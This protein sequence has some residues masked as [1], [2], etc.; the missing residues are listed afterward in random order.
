MSVEHPENTTDI[1]LRVLGDP[2]R[3]AEAERYYYAIVE[4]LN[5][6]HQ[7][8]EQDVMAL[9]IGFGLVVGQLT[10][11][12]NS[13]QRTGLLH[14][15]GLTADLHAKIFREAGMAAP[16]LFEADDHDGQSGASALH[17]AKGST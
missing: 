10:A 8:G 14:L 3:E 2:K 9:F 5:K 12:M 6:T 16:L 11:N 7:N 4:N 17:E 13:A 15:V 1:Y